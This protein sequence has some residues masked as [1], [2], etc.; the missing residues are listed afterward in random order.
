M[1]RELCRWD[2]GVILWMVT[3]DSKIFGLDFLESGLAGGEC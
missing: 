1:F 2:V 3:E